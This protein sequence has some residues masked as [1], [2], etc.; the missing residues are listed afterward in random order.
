MLVLSVEYRVQADMVIPPRRFDP[1][2]AN[3]FYAGF[4]A[5]DHFVGDAPWLEMVSFTSYGILSSCPAAV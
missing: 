4:L 3:P 5:S 2:S 1:K